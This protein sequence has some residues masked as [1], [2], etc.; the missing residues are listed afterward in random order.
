[1]AALRHHRR[2]WRPPWIAA[3]EVRGTQ[4]RVR[5]T[6]R[7]SQRVSGGTRMRRPLHAELIIT[8]AL[9]AVCPIA[10]LAQTTATPPASDRPASRAEDIEQ[11]QA[12]KAA[13]V[14]PY[15]PTKG[16][17]LFA[18]LDTVAQGGPLRWHPYF[19]SAYSGGG[20]TLG[21]GH[22][23]YVGDYNFIDAR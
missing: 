11:A 3:I 9:A 22:A 21:V 20:F 2:P 16:E 13:T 4:S 5:G 7:F 17:R 18:W 15:A 1:R 12:A 10:T 8:L 19:D 6:A 14:H 23:T